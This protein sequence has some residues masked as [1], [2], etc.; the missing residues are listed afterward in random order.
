M[1]PIW[2]G[3]W[4][5][6]VHVTG[7]ASVH[8]TR[9]ASVHVTR[10]ASVHVTGCVGVLGQEVLAWGSLVLIFWGPFITSPR[11]NPM[12]FAHALSDIF[13]PW[14]QKLLGGLGTRCR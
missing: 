12:N 2:L 5:A 1:N 10:V 8:V 7:L 14:G 11:S 6:S 9:L 4:A 13:H 3:V